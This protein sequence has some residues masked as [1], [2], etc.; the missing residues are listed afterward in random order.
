MD[1]DVARAQYVSAES[2]EQKNH[3]TKDKCFDCSQKEHHHKNCSTNFY[4]IQQMT[5]IK[6]NKN[7]LTKRTYTE[8]VTSSKTSDKKT[9]SSFLHVITSQIMLFDESENKSF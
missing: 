8:F 1:I 4:K 5:M 7:A 3:L 9:H 6:S 2:D